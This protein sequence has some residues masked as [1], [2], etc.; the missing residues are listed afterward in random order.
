M[1]GE[2][3][4]GKVKAILALDA[5]Q[6]DK[7][8]GKAQSKMGDFGAKAS[9][10]GK[11]LSMKLT[12]P[13]VGA[14]AGA[15][16]MAMDFEQSMTQIQSL[17]GRSA[18]E[19]EQLS[20]IVKKL[21][22]ETA[23]SPK[24][25]A[26]AM[27]FITSAGL[28]AAAATK[29]LE[30]SAKAAA[31]GLGDTVAVADAVTNAMNGYGL[32]ADQASWA[33]D[34]LTKTVEQ[35]KAAASELA[36]TFG[37][38]IPVAAELGVEF[39]E[40][41]AGMAFLT[42]SS[43]DAAA[44]ATQ[45]RG[46]MNSILKPS[47]SAKDVLDQIGFSSKQFR[48]AVKDEGLLEGLLELRGRLED[49]G[50]EMANVF[51]NTRALAGALQLTGVQADQAV[52]V[53]AALEQSAGKTDEA[54]AIAADTTRFK[55]DKALTDFK[56]S[57]LTLGEK[58]VPMI[59]P[60]IQ[61]F[62]EFVAGLA[63]KFENLSPFMQKVVLGIG[64]FAAAAGPM[65]I[66]V[67]KMATGIT[68]LTGVFGKLAASAGFGA[69]K[70]AGGVL[71]KVGGLIKGHP[72]L[73]LASAAA[74]GVASFAFAK[75]RKRAEEARKRQKAL[76]QE[77]IDADDPASTLITRLKSMAEELESVTEASDDTKKEFEG[78][79]GE[80]TLYGLL[81]KDKVVPEFE[82]LGLSMED[83]LAVV[84]TGTDVFED[85]KDS[86]D[87]AYGSNEKFVK[88]L[89]L[90][91]GAEAEVANAIADR[92]EAGD[93]SLDQ[94]KKI[95]HS[96][97][98]TAD[99]FD[100]HGEELEKNAKKYLTSGDAMSDFGDILGND[101]VAALI[102]GA[103]E[104]KTYADV[105]AELETEVV[106]AKNQANL[107]NIVYDNWNFG[108]ESMAN[109]TLPDVEEALEEVVLTEEELAAEA[110]AA[111][112][113]LQD[114]I[115]LVDELKDSLRSLSDPLYEAEL[116]ESALAEAAIKME[117]AL[118]AS[119]GEIGTQTEE[120][121]E[122]L[123][124]V[125]SY[126][127]KVD[128]MAF[129]LQGLP[130]NEVNSALQ[131]QRAFLQ[132]LA[133]DGLINNERL[134]QLTGL[135]DDA[136]DAITEISA[137]EMLL[138]LDVEI[139]SATLGLLRQFQALGSADFGQQYA[140]FIGFGTTAGAIHTTRLQRGGVEMAEGGIVTK[141]TFP[142]LAGESGAEAIIPLDQAGGLLGGGGT[143]INVTVQGSVLSEM[144]LSD[145]IQA[146]LIRTKNRNASLEF[147]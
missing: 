145:A 51:E 129:N 31:S 92:V 115:D 73:F 39:D 136:F 77:F 127:D 72:A 28:D 12:A 85:L 124:A 140:D 81:L 116:A 113:K 13:I 118:E 30:Y 89:R 20:G 68:A 60:L 61:K 88:G 66:I 71:S 47:Q 1:A 123:D 6:W 126:A 3:I 110:E 53:F 63:E 2:A 104:G 132:G 42:R 24:E 119:N 125:A 59:L 139:D 135:L 74:I 142:I 90:V 117:E 102:A 137:S 91:R 19:V 80:Q 101:V 133:D 17:V 86:V 48:Q 111:N 106:A 98:E 62:G 52:E 7:A 79:A 34:V 121:R 103:D 78:L 107:A 144:D 33:T 55:F 147:G 108:M 37:K 128:D 143:T 112:K 58:I 26:D 96:L 49:N 11:T 16:K 99:A 109:N 38:M 36:P 46:I 114:Q 141:P 14:A 146:Q 120:A 5:A 8:I 57:M 64:A 4:V 82:A 97:D 15:F 138:N 105:L 87:T 75:M 27:F 93:L 45:L 65:L 44:S 22:G 100:N 41:G 21:A 134:D 76:T 131:D 84:S 23:K 130:L 18:E 95:L 94:A 32:S 25:L 40:V 29:A 83:T 35:G 54:F 43:G 56:L 50:F 10:T 9:K 70:G 67:G 69:G 122:A